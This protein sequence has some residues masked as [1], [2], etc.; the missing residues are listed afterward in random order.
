[1]RHLSREQA[2]GLQP[3]RDNVLIQLE[4]PAKKTSGGIFLPDAAKKRDAY[5]RVI[6]IGEGERVGKKRVL[7]PLT[8]QP[9]DIVLLPKH[10]DPDQGEEQGEHFVIGREAELLAIVGRR[11]RVSMV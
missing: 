4:A 6:A 9:G 3:V 2:K 10:Y 7:M 8:V 11:V 5:G 1:V